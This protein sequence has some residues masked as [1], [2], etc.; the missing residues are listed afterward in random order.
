MET[1]ATRKIGLK[2]VLNNPKMKE[3]LVELLENNLDLFIRNDK[4]RSLLGPKA[5]LVSE[6]SSILSYINN[7]SKKS[8]NANQEAIIRTFA[9]PVM[10]ISNDSLNLEEQGL[11]AIA[12]YQQKNALYKKKQAENNKGGE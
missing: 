2:R 4:I 8:I 3:G 1:T 10:E 12:Y 7:P 6:T 5:D 11:F 9:R